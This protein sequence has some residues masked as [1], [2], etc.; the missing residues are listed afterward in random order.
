[1]TINIRAQGIDMTD[2]IRSY[3]EDKM[4]SLEKFTPEILIADVVVGKETSHHHKGDIF[5]CSATLQVPGDV[6][7]VEREEEDLYK[8]IDKVRDHLRE[9]LAQ[10]KERTVDEHKG[11]GEG[12][13]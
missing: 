13:A 7:R 12:T 10:R 4:T 8:A 11:V 2:A 9:T 3:A 1:M 5:K 6:L